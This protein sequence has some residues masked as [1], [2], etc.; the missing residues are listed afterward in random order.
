MAGRRDYTELSTFVCPECG[1]ELQLPRRHGQLR[2]QGHIKDIYCPVCKTERKFK[3]YTHKQFY[4]TLDGDV[5]SV[6]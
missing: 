1:S 5:I 2:E 4:K 3:E 6:Q